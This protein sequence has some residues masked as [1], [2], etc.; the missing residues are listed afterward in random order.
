MIRLMRLNIS[1][2]FMKMI[3]YMAIA[4]LL[5][6][7]LLSKL[8]YDKFEQIGFDNAYELNQKLLAQLTYNIEYMNETV[9][10]L[11]I[12]Q[13]FTP[14][15][16]LLMQAKELNDFDR[17]KYVH[18]FHNIIVNNPMLH[19][20]VLY[21]HRLQQ[22]H[23]IGAEEDRDLQNMLKDGGSL[24]V[25]KP[26]PRILNENDTLIPVFTY[27]MFEKR[28]GNVLEDGALILN[29]KMD[30]LRGELLKW[31]D[32]DT[33]YMIVDGSGR[34]IVDARERYRPFESIEWPI[35]RQP[36][37]AGGK[38]S[39]TIATEDGQKRVISSHAI[40]GTDW[41]F[42]SDAPYDSLFHFILDTRRQTIIY[43]VLAMLAAVAVSVALSRVFYSPIANLV[44]KVMS[45]A[46]EM[47]DA[48][49]ETDYIAKAFHSSIRQYE[50][51]KTSTRELIKENVLKSLLTESVS[52]KPPVMGEA[53]RE[54]E[55]ICQ[56]GRSYA[57]VLLTFDQTR[58]YA[59]M[60]NSERQLVKLSLFNIADEV[61][62]A[63]A[64]CAKTDLGDG[65]YAYLLGTDVQ[66][67]GDAMKHL[68]EQIRMI[69]SLVNRV[70]RMMTISAIIGQSSGDISRLS[71]L[72]KNTQRL[73]QY[74][75]SLGSGCLI[76]VGDIPE[77]D[78][79]SDYPETAERKLTE[80]I[81]AQNA[82]AMKEAFAQFIASLGC[83]DN[84]RLSLSLLQLS[85][86][87]GR[88]LHEMNRSRFEKIELDMDRFHGVILQSDT[89]E[90]IRRHFDQLFE[91]V[92]RQ[93]SQS[94]ATKHQVIVESVIG[95][96]HLHLTDEELSPKAIAAEF[97][98]SV[99]HLS[100]LFKEAAQ[101]S[102]SRYIFDLRM[103]KVRYLLKSTDKSVREIAASSGFHN[104]A[105]FYKAFK[106]EFGV[107]PNEYRMHA[108]VEQM[109]RPGPM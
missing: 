83:C 82:E 107:T 93:S 89:L 29:V 1:K 20:A 61:F 86:A 95:Y 56:A 18:A 106:N 55:A 21:N 105:S 8:L 36:E 41:T 5:M 52:A 76:E 7:A 97:R 31:I 27:Y 104:E 102:I 88:T 57:L 26:V 45:V 94:V 75:M 100:E 12:T 23:Y 108:V 19:S 48:K 42:V 78:D 6:V 39:R 84:Q 59:R 62:G 38:E 32:D 13:Y 92:V 22:Y 34:V 16:I 37:T 103:E 70:S 65:E 43:A 58:L 4:M 25:L 35:A 11:S 72:F 101:K 54:L 66:G 51:Y 90:E 96:I 85:L 50:V 77:R 30:W 44:K 10:T 3:A 14:G 80:A 91:T 60:P 68:R 109:K 73:R 33:H 49:D 46:G 99:G 98:L 9:R 69:Q 63:W 53:L 74:Q 67:M 40:P 28:G 87:I 47:S 71:E 64:A 2:S 81:K 17:I 24:P 15:N 79:K